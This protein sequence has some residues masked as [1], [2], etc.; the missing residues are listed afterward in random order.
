MGNE[1]PVAQALLPCLPLAGRVC[2]ADA[3]HT[4]KEFMD[5]VDA[6]SGKTLLTVKN[7]QPTLYADLATYFADPH[8]SFLQDTTLD[9]GHNP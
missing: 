1:I 8:A 4:H 3:I 7:N 5:G 6:L 2:T 9:S